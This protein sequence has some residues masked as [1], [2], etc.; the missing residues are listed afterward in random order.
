MVVLNLELDNIYAKPSIEDCVLFNTYRCIK[1]YCEEYDEG[2]AHFLKA[3]QKYF[4][5]I[6]TKK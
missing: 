3:Y 6:P 1:K 5:N 4:K 2:K